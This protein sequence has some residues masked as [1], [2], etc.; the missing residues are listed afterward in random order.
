VNSAGADGLFHGN[1]A[2]LG[3]QV[4]AIASVAVYAFVLT[5]VILKLVGAV[6][7]LRLERD[8]EDLGLDISQ[9]GEAGYI[10]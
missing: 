10:F 8:D 1:A 2:L 5:F 3:K 7:A 9:H 6:T 4:I